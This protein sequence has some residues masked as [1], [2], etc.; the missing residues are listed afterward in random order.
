MAHH[1][2][3]I[4]IGRLL[5]PIDDPLIA[6]F[7]AQLDEINALAESSPGFIWRLTGDGNDA[8][9]LHP[10]SDNLVIVNMSVWES[11]DALKNF[12]FKSAHAVVM[13]RRTD[14][15]EKFPTAYL[16]LWWIEAG[17]VPTVDEAKARLRSLDEH[18][19]S[20]YAFTFRKLFDP[21]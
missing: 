6:D 11:I 10:F 16:A 12:A 17:H 20:A 7:A 18:G 4:N 1:L 5:A 8:T 2:A 3:Q 9:S 15:F 13:R 19:D 14:W 21:S